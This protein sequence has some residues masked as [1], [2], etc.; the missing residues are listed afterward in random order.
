MVRRGN[1]VFAAI[2]RSDR[3]RRKR[4]AVQ[5]LFDAGDHGRS[6]SQIDGRLNWGK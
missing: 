1:G 3:E 6:L 4:R 2:T 5:Q